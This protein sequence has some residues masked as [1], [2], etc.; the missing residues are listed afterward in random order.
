[1]SE[2]LIHSQISPTARALVE[3]PAG[4]LFSW[5]DHEGYVTLCD[6]VNVPVGIALR[7]ITADSLVSPNGEWLQRGVIVSVPLDFLHTAGM[8]LQTAADGAIE[9]GADGMVF[10][11]CLQ[12]GDSGEEAQI[13]SL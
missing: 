4:H 7:T 3:I 5:S 10:A 9:E 13:F 8:Y 11:Q 1:M 2:V 6:A 12:D